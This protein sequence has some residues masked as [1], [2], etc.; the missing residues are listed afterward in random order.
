MIETLTAR[1]VYG[2][3]TSVTVG[4]RVATVTGITIRSR[5]VLYEVV[6]W[7]GPVANASGLK[8]ARLLLAR[9]PSKIESDSIHTGFFH[10]WCRFPMVRLSRV[11]TGQIPHP[12]S[13]T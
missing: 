10:V 2:I 6:W 8:S 4:G 3:G 11:D 5:G 13:P 1:S 12:Q 9:I 7:D